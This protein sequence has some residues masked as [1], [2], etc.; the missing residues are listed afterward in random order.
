[1]YPL[2][3]NRSDATRRAGCA[4]AA[5][6]QMSHNVE[7]QLQTK[8][9][10][11]YQLNK[12]DLETVLGSLVEKII[13]RYEAAKREPRLTIKQVSQRLQVDPSTLWRWERDGYLI[14]T[15]LGR[16]VLYNESDIA[17]IEEGRI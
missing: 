3:G 11:Q 10:I 17:A 6:N 2:P 14:P 4:G 16:K 8:Q 13:S 15:R 12:E 5:E 7:E 9:F 1:M